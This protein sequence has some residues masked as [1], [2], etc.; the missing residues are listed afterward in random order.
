MALTPDQVHARDNPLDMDHVFASF[1]CLKNQ[2]QKRKV[3]ALKDLAKKPRS[4]V[5]ELTEIELRSV[6]RCVNKECT[7]ILRVDEHVCYTCARVQEESWLEQPTK[8][9]MIFKFQTHSINCGYRR[10]NHFNEKLAQFQGKE[11]T[12]IPSNVYAEILSEVEKG[13]MRK[14]DM[15]PEDVKYILKK[16]G[17]GK[18]YEHV[19]YITNKI[20]G[21]ELPGLTLDQEERLRNMFNRIQVPFS[22]HAPTH[23]KNFLNYAYIFRKFFELLEWD[24]LINNFSEL[25]SREKLY[26][27]DKVW[28]KIVKEL[29]WEFIPSV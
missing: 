17:K 9:E 23:R 11:R 26:E 2:T 24:H 19:N 5:P 6:K 15:V 22:K 29:G 8:A 1:D 18:F 14:S 12:E 3:V 13:G 27:Q 28:E 10:I 21:Y 7:Q 20:N 4:D 16:L 25:K